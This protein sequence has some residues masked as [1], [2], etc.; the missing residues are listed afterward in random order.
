MEN[1]CQKD[2]FGP[3]L[4]SN[5][6]NKIMVSAIHKNSQR[7]VFLKIFRKKFKTTNMLK[8]TDTIEDKIDSQNKQKERSP[9]NLASPSAAVEASPLRLKRL[10]T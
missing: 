9:N 8:D 3:Q 7:N 4:L 2:E 10:F 5:N 1:C 6:Q